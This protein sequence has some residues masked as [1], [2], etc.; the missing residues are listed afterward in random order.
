[1]IKQ[2]LTVSVVLY[3]CMAHPGLGDQKKYPKI[4]GP[5]IGLY[6]KNLDDC[7]A[8]ANKYVALVASRYKKAAIL[9]KPCV[10][11]E[12]GMGVGVFTVTGL[13]E[14]ESKEMGWE[15]PYDLKD[16]DCRYYPLD[17]N[18]RFAT[19]ETSIVKLGWSCDRAGF[20]CAET[21]LC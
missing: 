10:R 1:M 15:K 3:L 8:L 19:S 4:K 14:T 17:G 20:T 7:T 11:G 12:G 13:T 9:T 21:H 5:P 16:T 6:P 18:K 2:V